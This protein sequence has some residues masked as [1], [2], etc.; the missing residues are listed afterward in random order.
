MT[1]GLDQTIDHLVLPFLGL[2]DKGWAN[3]TTTI[4]QEHLASAVLRTFLQNGRESFPSPPNAPIAIFTTL[5]GEQH[6]LGALIVASLAAMRG[7]ASVYLGPNLPPEEITKAARASGASLIGLSIVS[8]RPAEQLKEEV[9]AIRHGVD[10]H[11]QILLGGRSAFA[12]PKMAGIM[13]IDT[14]DSVRRFLEGRAP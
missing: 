7:W 5:S 6:E 13:V 9:A 1:L 2:I 14:M 3:G 12:A 10:S 8:P 4:A 11:V